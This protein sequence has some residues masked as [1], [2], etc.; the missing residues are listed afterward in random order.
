V[1]TPYSSEDWRSNVR[2]TSVVSV[3]SAGTVY[4]ADAEEDEDEPISLAQRILRYGV[5]LGLIAL[6]VVAFL[7]GP[8]INAWFSS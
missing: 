6:L 2:G 5:V 4:R 3:E 8:A 7:Y 1:E